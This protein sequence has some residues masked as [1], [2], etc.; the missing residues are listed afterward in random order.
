MCQPLFLEQN[1]EL[2]FIEDVKPALPFIDSFIVD[3]AG[4]ML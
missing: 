1:M 3:K 2:F 4:E